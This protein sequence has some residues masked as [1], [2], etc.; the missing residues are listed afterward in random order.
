MSGIEWAEAGKGVCVHMC[1]C[2]GG[3]QEQAGEGADG[4]LTRSSACKAMSIRNTKS[5]KKKDT[6]TCMKVDALFL[7]A[8][9]AAWR[10]RDRTSACVIRP[11]R[12]GGGGAG[13]VYKAGPS[14]TARPSKRLAATKKEV[15]GRRGAGRQEAGRGTGNSGGGERGW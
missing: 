7:S 5:T 12:G 15:G 14:E 8:R 11:R 1:V 2:V 9:S 6:P 3:V 13:G 10:A 4:E